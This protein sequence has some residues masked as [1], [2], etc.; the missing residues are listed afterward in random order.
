M[1][2]MSREARDRDKISKNRS[3]VNWK[4]IFQLH[5]RCQF[6]FEKMRIKLKSFEEANKDELLVYN[7]DGKTFKIAFWNLS[8]MQALTSITNANT[9]S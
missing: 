1:S 7:L 6:K 2:E 4:F 9:N 3:C 5:S 8:L